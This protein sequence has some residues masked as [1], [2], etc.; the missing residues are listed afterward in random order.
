MKTVDVARNA[1]G[2]LP[3]GVR[4]ALKKYKRYIYCRYFLKPSDSDMALFTSEWLLAYLTRRFGGRVKSQEA[5]L[6][7]PPELVQTE[8]LKH[9]DNLKDLYTSVNYFGSG[10]R[11][12]WT[13]LTLLEK[14]GAHTGRYGR[15][16]TSAVAVPE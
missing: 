2:I 13:M 6:I 5:G 12:V 1:S 11:D 9:A 3:Y 16:S 14:Y 10:R 15:F 7:A 8:A 4:S